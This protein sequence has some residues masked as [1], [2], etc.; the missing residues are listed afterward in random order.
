MHYG[1]ILRADGA[2]EGWQ[3]GD[4]TTPYPGEHVIAAGDEIIDLSAL[5]EPD[6]SEV[7]R[8]VLAQPSTE[9][10]RWVQ[11]YPRFM[12]PTLPHPKALWDSRV[13]PGLRRIVHR[14][15]AK[16]HTQEIAARIR[17]NIKLTEGRPQAAVISEF[18]HLS[19]EERQQRQAELLQDGRF[20]LIPLVEF[21]RYANGQVERTYP[22]HETVWRF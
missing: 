12:V 9:R 21:T 4:P 17:A 7:I 15:S 5:T 18:V 11:L 1:M 14:P 10:A 19:N 22:W 20:P 6:A 3:H 8:F 2:T 16:W 13:Q